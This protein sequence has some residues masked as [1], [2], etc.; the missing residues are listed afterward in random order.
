MPVPTLPDSDKLA[1]AVLTAAMPSQEFGTQI[2]K[3]L[4]DSLPY[5]TVARF[6]GASV[7]PRFLDSA[8]VDMQT[9]GATRKDAF[10]LAHAC[11]NAFRDAWLNGTV[12]DGIGH[13]SHFREIT[14]PSELRTAD[15][16]DGLWRT[17]ATYSLGMRP[18]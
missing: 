1:L 5:A 14:G 6:G 13:I 8:T 7:D 15:Q 10:D 18:A 4:L 12:Y 3:D 9:W 11:R 16:A 2:P 17:Q